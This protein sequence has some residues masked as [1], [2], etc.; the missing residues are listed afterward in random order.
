MKDFVQGHQGSFVAVP[1][2]VSFGLRS[3]VRISNDKV[4][5]HFWERE[6]HEE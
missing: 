3:V 1:D 6:G 4:E 2:G 5:G